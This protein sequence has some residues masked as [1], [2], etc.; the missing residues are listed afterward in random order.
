MFHRENDAN[1]FFVTIKPKEPV[2]SVWM[3]END[4]EN[5]QRFADL[6]MKGLSKERVEELSVKIEGDCVY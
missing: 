3:S 1:Y 6:F 5:I 2:D 4:K